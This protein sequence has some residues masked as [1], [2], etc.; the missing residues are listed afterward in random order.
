MMKRFVLALTAA[1]A[2][3]SLSAPASAQ[4]W[5]KDRATTQGPGIR[6]GDFELH[7]G[8]AGEIGYDSNYFNRAPNNNTGRVNGGPGYPIVD[9]VRLRITPSFYITTLG[10]QRRPDGSAAPRPKATLTAGAA[11]IYSQF[12][13]NAG[14]DTGAT[15]PQRNKLGRD[16]EYG[17]AGDFILNIAPGQPWGLNLIDNFQRTA[18]PGLDPLVEAGLNRIENRAAAEIV[19]TR[20]GGL[21]DW[22]LGYAYGL[23]HFENGPFATNVTSAQDFN[24]TRHE[25]YTS[26]RWRFLPRTALVYNGSYWIQQYRNES[27]GLASS[28]PLRTRIGLSGLVTDRF[29]VLALVG[30]GSSFYSNSGTGNRDF[31]SVIGQLEFRYF[32]SGSAPEAGT[33]NTTATSSVAL[34]VTRDFINSYIGNYQARNRAYFG[35]STMIGQRFLLTADA[36]AAV[37]QYSDVL[38]RGTGQTLV[39]AFSTLRADATLFAEYRVKDWLGF[40]ATYQFLG[41]FSDQRLPANVFRTVTY[42]MGFQRHQAFVGVRAFF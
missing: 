24:N 1:S 40:N 12:L 25:I 8:I 4:V 42:S 38:D 19:H 15:A 6:S 7:P 30:W 2:L 3:V 21:L 18:Q 35:L 17:I 31:D 29:A 32:L 34:G 26:G 14:E 33:P 16:F 20:P 37:I 36:G 9:T 27:P 23:T 28:R 22:R 11:F 10:Q 39:T 5:L 13:M 41:E